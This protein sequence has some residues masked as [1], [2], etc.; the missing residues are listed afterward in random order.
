M[1]SSVNRAAEH[2]QHARHCPLLGKHRLKSICIAAYAAGQLCWLASSRFSEGYELWEMQTMARHTSDRPLWR[3]HPSGQRLD[4]GQY[5]CPSCICGWADWL[6][7]QHL[8][9]SSVL[10]LQSVRN[11]DNLARRTLQIAHCTQTCWIILCKLTNLYLRCIRHYQKKFHLYG[12][13]HFYITL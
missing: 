12:W 1:P 10:R 9:A 3:W 5:N 6:A 11:L 4:A 2:R 7:G 8:I 13:D